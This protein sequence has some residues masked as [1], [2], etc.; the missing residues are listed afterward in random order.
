MREYKLLEITSQYVKYIKDFYRENPN[1]DDLTYDE[2]FNMFTEQGFA[3]ANFIHPYLRNMGIESKVIFYNNKTLQYKWSPLCKNLSLFELLLMQIKEYCPDIILIS[4]MPSFDLEQL[5]MIKESVSNKTIYLVGYYFSELNNKFF[6]VVSQYD[7]IYTGSNGYVNLMRNKEIPA[8]LLR[9]AFDSSIINKLD[10]CEKSNAVCF[11][12]SIVVGKTYHNNRIEILN[13]MMEYKIPYDFYGEIYGIQK[14][15]K[16]LKILLDKIENNRHDANYG[17]K[18]YSIISQYTIGLNLHAPC[19]DGAGNMRMFETT[20]VGTC[21]LTDYRD[22]N[23]EMFD[24]DN[25][26]VEYSSSEELLDKVRWLIN[27][28]SKAKEIAKAGQKRT[29]KDHTYKNKAEQLNEYI[30]KLLKK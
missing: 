18:Y 9:H 6:E 1:V 2:L 4:D 22:E 14:E 20:G 10:V 16:N 11:S 13:K 24:V 3:E 25:E 27:Y 7:Q 26:I 17:I 12:G 15:D 21:L 29:L 28:P 5:K 19:I 23:C 8:F 30:Q